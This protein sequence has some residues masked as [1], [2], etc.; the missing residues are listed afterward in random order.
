MESNKE[1]E[2]GSFLHEELKESLYKKISNQIKF[3]S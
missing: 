1:I 2:I 3:Y